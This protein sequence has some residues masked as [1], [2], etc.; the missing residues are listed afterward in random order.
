ME[1][2]ASYE[3]SVLYTSGK[4][5]VVVDALNRRR[6]ML[7]YMFWSGS[8]WC[9]FLHSISTFIR[10]CTMIISN[11]IC[12]AFIYGLYRFES[13]ARTEL[14]GVFEKLNRGE[15]SSNLDMYFIDSTK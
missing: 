5:N 15:H 12:L 1:Y 11:C 8:T 9:L 10:P 4:C 13:E 3:F 7:C 2:F 6:M 14:L